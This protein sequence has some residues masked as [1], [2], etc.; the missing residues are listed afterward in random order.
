MVLGTAAPICNL[1]TMDWHG[2][3]HCCSHFRTK[4]NGRWPCS[5]TSMSLNVVYIGN[6]IKCGKAGLSV[7]C[8]RLL[9]KITKKQ[10]ET[11]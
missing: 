6:V 2:V 3:R 4:I 7:W 1:L 10:V 8:R 9:H 5:G 11:V